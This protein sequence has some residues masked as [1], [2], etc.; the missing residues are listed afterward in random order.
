[1]F[2]MTDSEFYDWKSQ[3]V[4]SIAIN[5]GLRKIPFVFTELGMAMPAV[6]VL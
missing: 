5:M 6:A 3:I 2:Q 4:I 1:M